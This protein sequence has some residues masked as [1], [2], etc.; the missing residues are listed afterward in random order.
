VVFLVGGYRFLSENL[1][2]LP[3]IR[4]PYITSENWN[5][6]K[7][8]LVEFVLTG[9]PVLL[10]SIFSMLAS[11]SNVPVAIFNII[12]VVLGIAYAIYSIFTYPYPK[13]PVKKVSG[14]PP[15][16]EKFVN[17]FFGF[18]LKYLVIPFVL[19]SSFLS[20]IY[21]NGKKSVAIEFL[22]TLFEH[23]ERSNYRLFK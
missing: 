23:L 3:D 8:G 15:Y 7:I 5:G 14:R 13:E 4:G 18:V 12:A 11:G 2:F 9:I 6:F 16:E 19:V 22:E 21:G 1:E 20:F 10:C 17:I